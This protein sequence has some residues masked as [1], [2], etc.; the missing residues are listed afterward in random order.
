MMKQKITELVQELNKASEAYYNGEKEIMSN[1]E[2]DAMFDELTKLELESG[3]ILPDSPT[4][5]VSADNTKGNKEKHEFPALSLDKT[6]SVDDLIRWAENKPVWLSWKL[7]GLTLVA[8]YDNGKLSKLMTRGNGIVGTNITW[9]AESIEHLPRF[10]DY[11]GHMVVRGEAVIS[12]EDFERINTSLDEEN[13]YKNPRNLAS[14]TMNLDDISE[15]KKRH[16]QFIAFTPVYFDNNSVYD[17]D[18]RFWADRM[19]YLDSLGFKTVSRIPCQS[20]YSR[21]KIDEAVDK[22]TREVEF[23]EFPVDGLVLCYDDWAYSQSGSVTEHH[24]TRGGYAFKW[25]DE[26]AETI[27]KDVVYE[28]TRTGIISEVAV[29]EPVELCGTTVSKALIPNLNYR[30][31]MDLK[32]GDRIEVF[33]A[34]MIIP[35]IARNLDADNNRVKIINDSKRYQL[36]RNCP[37]CGGEVA[38]NTSLSGTMN[39]ICNNPYCD[40]KLIKSIAHFCEKEC[41]DIDG[42]SETKIAFLID[43]DYISGPASLYH[44]A[45]EYNSSGKIVNQYNDSLAD[46]DGWGEKSVANLVKA[47]DKSRKT[48]FVKFI[49]AMGIPNVGKGQAKLLAPAIVKWAKETANKSEELIQI[50]AEMVWLDYDFTLIDGFGPVIAKSLSNWV[51]A[52]ITDVWYRNIPET[53]VVKLLKELTFVDAYTDNTENSNASNT[54]ISGKTFVIT[55]DVH[56]FKNRKEIQAKIESLGGKA[57]GSVT[58]KTDYLIN[59]DINSTSSK[60]KKAK[61][62]N[63][64][65]ISEEEFINMINTTR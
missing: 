33:K 14:G 9:M 6:K 26:T 46:Y 28:T 2:W 56:L 62:L 10:I 1:Y 22:F 52:N 7:D 44:I 15:I 57:T 41:M 65:I 24:A 38:I 42:L 21:K 47:I 4:Q 17:F 5:R 40:S 49:H 25:Q 12:Y 59:N 27:L 30:A 16:I 31:D 23:F 37:C 32:I 39:L 19:S 64:P 53:E 43:H 35:Q 8:T 13:R 36:P 51:D 61:E 54:A 3:I 58:S 34:N 20:S 18:F 60:N 45:S 63:I 29:F 11:K 48:T 50:L 55:G